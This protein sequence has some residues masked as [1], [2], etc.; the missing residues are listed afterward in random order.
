[1]RDAH[2]PDD[3]GGNVVE[4]SRADRVGERFCAA[5]WVGN[6]Q[7]SLRW[8]AEVAPERLARIELN[9]LLQRVIVTDDRAKA[10]EDL[11]R[12]W[13]PLIAADQ[14]FKRGLTSGDGGLHQLAIRQGPD[15]C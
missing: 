2:G 6:D 12:Q 4:A 8:I 5:V 11:S 14:L 7:K 1:M 10:A 13:A 9:A 3:V 15:L